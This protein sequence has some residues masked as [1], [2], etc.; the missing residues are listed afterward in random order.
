MEIGIGNK[1]Q[2]RE[3]TPSV[4]LQN[5]NASKRKNSNSRSR[6]TSPTSTIGQSEQSG[7]SDRGPSTSEGVRTKIQRTEKTSKGRRYGPNFD[8]PGYYISFRHSNPSISTLS[9]GI[10]TEPS[11]QSFLRLMYSFSEEITECDVD[12]T[13][14]EQYMASWN[15]LIIKLNSVDEGYEGICNYA[16]LW[17][18]EKYIY[19][20]IILCYEF[21]E[22]NVPHCHVMLKTLTRPDNIRTELIKRFGDHH[23]DC[24]RAQKVKNFRALLRY[25]CKNPISFASTNLDFCKCI[26]WYTEVE[27]Y[28]KI[29]NNPE[30]TELQPICK[31]IIDCMEKYNIHTL[32]ELMKKAPMVMGK[33]LHKTNL[34]SIVANCRQ[35]IKR[36]QGIDKI[37]AKLTNYSEDPVVIHTLL[38]F[39]DID[40]NSFDIAFAN[41]IFKK[42]GKKNVICLRGPSNTGKSSFVRHL[43]SLFSCGTVLN[44]NQFTFSHCLNKDLLLWEE[45]LISPD[46]AETCKIIFEGYP[47]SVAI[48]YKDAQTLERVP[49]I[50]TTNRDPWNYCSQ[51]KEAFLNRIYMFDFDRPITEL[52]G[53]LSTGIAELS[54]EFSRCSETSKHRKPNFNVSFE[55]S[56]YK[57]P[58]RCEYCFNSGRCV[59]NF[60]SCT[61][62][63]WRSDIR[64]SKSFNRRHSTLCRFY[65]YRRSRRR[66]SPSGN[67]SDS[68]GHSERSSAST[69][70]SLR[71]STE[72]GSSNSSDGENDSDGSDRSSGQ[73]SPRPDRLYYRASG[74]SYGYGPLASGTRFRGLRRL[75]K[76]KQTTDNEDCGSTSEAIQTESTSCKRR[77][78][79]WKTSLLKPPTQDDWLNYI[80]Y[81]NFKYGENDQFH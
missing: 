6:K 37:L 76:K 33:Y 62:P 78:L 75:Y 25:M 51:N 22:K 52:D 79:G 49:I 43:A 32:E 26:V 56:G 10:D 45:P 14:T 39:Q 27:K 73:I 40:P 42:K 2:G 28:V 29:I 35:W 69:N 64:R 72:H 46:L 9:R 30:C 54:G 1:E 19:N 60:F 68:S 34:E 44:G 5:A 67:S 18:N 17:E 71:S 24:L 81:I 16:R 50:M 59:G 70:D 20:D 7:D 66:P 80:K 8:T 15:C 21:N 23:F 48:K 63:R 53:A 74:R 11:I 55:N 13:C 77:I 58:C 36:P 4:E 41:V 57:I 31:D 12:K 47:T 38:S 3:T 65:Y 61:K